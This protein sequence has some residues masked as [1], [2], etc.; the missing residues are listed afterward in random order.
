MSAGSGVASASEEVEM[1][2]ND[3]DMIDDARKEG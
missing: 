3:H 2:E 1:A